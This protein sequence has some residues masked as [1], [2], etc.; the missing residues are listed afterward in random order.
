[1]SWVV[2][3]EVLRQAIV[4]PDNLL[5]TEAAKVGAGVPG[6]DLRCT[7]AVYK[8]LENRYPVISYPKCL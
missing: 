3:N 1:M 8:L 2:H 5:I 4:L 6:P 7:A